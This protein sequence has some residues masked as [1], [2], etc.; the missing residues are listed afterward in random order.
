[1]KQDISLLDKYISSLER[2]K[3][4]LR[5]EGCKEIYVFG[6]LAAKRLSASSDIDIGIKGLDPKKF[7][8]VY[9][10]L[11]DEIDTKIDLVD[12]DS[13]IRFFEL[14]NGLGELQK[15]G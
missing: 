3:S 8:K 2:A 13:N 4:I 12:F 6:S 5:D 7:L 14:L 9:S 10:R 15:V 1:M 11:E